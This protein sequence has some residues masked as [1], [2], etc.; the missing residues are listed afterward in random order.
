MGSRNT[1]KEHQFQNVSQFV[2]K[3]QSV[4]KGEG[5]WLEWVRNEGESRATFSSLRN[6]EEQRSK[7]RACRHRHM[8]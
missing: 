6:S 7:A 3:P 2:S 4:R 5:L 1:I 8:N